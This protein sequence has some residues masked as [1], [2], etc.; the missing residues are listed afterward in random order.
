[1]QHGRNSTVHIQDIPVLWKLAEESIDSDLDALCVHHAV[2]VRLQYY[3]FLYHVVMVRKPSLSLEL[4][5]DAGLASAHMVHAA[6]KSS[7]GHVVGIDHNKHTTLAVSRDNR[8]TYIVADTIAAH[9][10]VERLVRVHGLIGVVFQ[11]SSHHYDH[12]C[13]EW[14]LYSRLLS[15]NAVWVCDDIHPAFRTPDESKGMVEYFQERPG[16]KMTIPYADGGNNVG[17]ILHD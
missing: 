2:S 10:D 17:V 4:G 6:R 13:K 8:Y 15:P 3:R 11:D 16:V 1:M 9:D 12:S 14:E 7:V 5:V